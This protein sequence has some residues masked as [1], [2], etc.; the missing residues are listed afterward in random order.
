MK[1]VELEC[2]NC[3]ATLKLEEGTEIVSCPYCKATY[4]LDDE[5]QHIKYDDMENSGYEFEKGRIKAQKEHVANNQNLNIAKI[6]MIIIPIIVVI[7]II[8]IIV[9]FGIGISSV[10]NGF[11]KSY[12]DSNND[13]NID[14]LKVNSEI[15]TNKENGKSE[16]EK[17]RFNLHYSNGRQAEIFVKS[18]LNDVI[19]SNKTNKDKIIT[20]KFNDIT[21]QDPEQILEIEKQLIDYKEY[22]VLLDYDEDGFVNMITIR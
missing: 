9:F 7:M 20:V 8:S 4:K 3:G 12:N 17:Y 1:L 22:D 18:M 11:E 19:T 5:A 15:E 13:I 6:P 16:Q 21:T 10:K 2:Q 14:E